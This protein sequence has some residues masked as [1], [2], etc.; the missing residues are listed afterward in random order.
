LL[1]HKTKPFNNIMT[2]KLSK[3][4]IFVIKLGLSLVKE[5][6]SDDKELQAQAI[7]L[8]RVLTNNDK[9]VNKQP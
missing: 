4:D 3:E 5:A 1:R 8:Q 6:A 9:A 2:I 7:N